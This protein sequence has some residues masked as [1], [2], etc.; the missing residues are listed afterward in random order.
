MLDIC[1]SREMKSSS[2]RERNPRCFRGRISGAAR[3]FQISNVIAQ[4]TIAHDQT[5]SSP[6]NQTCLCGFRAR[7][8]KVEHSDRL[9]HIGELHKRLILIGAN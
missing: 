2:T 8:V 7:P 3:A 4:Y 9:V 5:N 1:S 6:G